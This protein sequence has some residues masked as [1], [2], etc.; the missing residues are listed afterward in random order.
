MFHHYF[1]GV[2]GDLVDLVF[3]NISDIYELEL[4]ITSS[5]EEVSVVSPFASFPLISPV[6]H[7]LAKVNM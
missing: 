2:N 5:L 7:S 1:E 4:E 3:A 6:L